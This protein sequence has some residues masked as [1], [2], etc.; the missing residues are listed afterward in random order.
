MTK[1][2]D[3]IDMLKG[4]TILWVI[5]MHLNIP[6]I[7]DPSVQMPVFFF[8]SSCFFKL[9]PAKEFVM[10]KVNTLLI[11][12][13][14]FWMISWMIRVFENE[15]IPNYFDF[16]KIIWSDVFNIFTKYSYMQVNIL[17]FLMALFL[18]NLMYFWLLKFNCSKKII[19]GLSILFY[20]IGALI[21]TNYLKYTCTMFPLAEI[22]IFQLWFLIGLL[23]GKTL[24]SWINAP[25]EKRMLLLLSVSVI[26]MFSITVIDWDKEFLQKIPYLIYM[27][28]YTLSFIILALWVFRKLAHCGWMKI[29]GYYGTNSLIVYVT[30]MLLI[31]SFFRAYMNSIICSAI[32]ITQDNV[33]YLIVVFIV[34]CLIEIGL[35]IFF[36]RY[37][38]Q[39]VGKKELITYYHGIKE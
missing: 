29:F 19:A 31:H 4:F 38:P 33:Y 36:N 6:S 21:R 37:F 32:G 39:F 25:L 18:V 11:P 23:F 3:Y 17:W 8:L 26:T 15:F 24:F 10:R 13:L 9:R 12:L 16:S 5:W 28:P 7:I 14:F 20:I 22:L 2:I 30:H 27:I 35:I 34:I 1:R